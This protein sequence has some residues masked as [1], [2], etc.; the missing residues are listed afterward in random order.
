MEKEKE[1]FECFTEKIY[2]DLQP[3]CYK[4]FYRDGYVYATDRAI[5]VRVPYSKLRGLYDRVD[6]P[7]RIP[8]LPTPNCNYKLPLDT[9]IKT[10]KSIPAEEVVPVQGIEAECNECEGTGIVEWTY[11]DSDG[12]DHRDNFDCPICNGMG[13]VKTKKYL[14][15]WRCISI[16]ETVLSVRTLMK[17]AEAMHI[18]G[19][20]TASILNLPIGC[21]PTLVRL[22]EDIEII[23]MPCP[24]AKPVREIKI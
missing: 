22:G 11:E 6:Y 12:E 3:F 19:I 13:K 15:E 2:V 5:M 18:A 23:I 20:E 10:I 9:L 1:F 17:L 21:T 16:N 24:E 7:K 14:R 8:A 4:P